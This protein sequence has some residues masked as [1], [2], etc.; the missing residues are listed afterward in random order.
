MLGKIR[1]RAEMGSGFLVTNDV[2]GYRF[3]VL[4]G[5]QVWYYMLVCRD[6]C[7]V[8][9]SKNID[10]SRRRRFNT[11][12]FTYGLSKALLSTGR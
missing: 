4:V 11:S 8:K 12:R 6:H 5:F 7:T 10:D 9:R 3:S 2:A 1:T